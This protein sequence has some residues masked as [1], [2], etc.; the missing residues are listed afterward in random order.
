M[1]TT[2]QTCARLMT[3]LEELLTQETACV[4]HGDFG[5][6][7]QLQTQAGPLVDFLGVHG[8]AAA[9]ESLVMRVTRWAS[10]RQSNQALMATEAERLGRELREL[11]AA[12]RTVKRVAPAYGQVSRASPRLLTIG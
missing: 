2:A 7:A 4:R 3:A 11:E 12:G 8:P 10:Q 9:D 5:L 6:L 1:A